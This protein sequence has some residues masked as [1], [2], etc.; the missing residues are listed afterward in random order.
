MI[1]P[2][3]ITTSYVYKPIAYAIN[4]SYDKALQARYGY[5]K[6]KADNIKNRY[7]K[8]KYWSN[9]ITYI[10]QID[11][12]Y[13]IIPEQ[14]PDITKENN[15]YYY[16]VSQVGNLLYSISMTETPYEKIKL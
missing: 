9:F 2:D 6:S 11:W 16:N 5:C 13:P 1:K 8:I 3:K 10:G 7:G 15:K 4:Y 14:D 12:D